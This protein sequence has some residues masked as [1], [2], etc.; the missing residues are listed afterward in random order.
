MELSCVTPAMPP[1]TM[2]EIALIHLSFDG[3]QSFTP[4]SCQFLIYPPITVTSIHPAL[5]F[6]D[7][8]TEVNSLKLHGMT[9]LPP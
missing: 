9:T 3:A 2:P 8:P 5:G 4:H 1:V 6:S 7:G